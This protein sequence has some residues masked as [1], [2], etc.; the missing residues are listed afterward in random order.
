MGTT[1]EEIS[2]G[3][4]LLCCHLVFRE[5]YTPQ[6]AV[7]RFSRISGI[8]I[9]PFRGMSNDRTVYALSI[10]DCLSGLIK[11]QARG[12]WDPIAFDSDH[13]LDLIQ[14]EY[15]LTVISPKIAV[16]SCPT[17]SDLG[18][19]ASALVGGLRSHAEVFR[20][21]GA[22]QVVRI[23]QGPPSHDCSQLVDE[24]FAVDDILDFD[25]ENPS[26]DVID[27]F[28]G[29][30]NGASGLVAVYCRD[31]LG[32]SCTL[33]ACYLIH[34]HGFSAAEAIGYLRVMRP[35]SIYG[36]QQCFLEDYADSVLITAANAP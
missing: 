18:G 25:S 1:P 29:V 15:N 34:H 7:S 28:L 35:G 26:Q 9:S 11:A 21:I 36:E 10:L 22:M 4:L 5:D 33:V 20:C 14:P 2:S 30:V 31:G 8:P 27:H 3:V 24:G 16:L 13:Y 23:E 32:R 12:L 6:E 19:P 17:S